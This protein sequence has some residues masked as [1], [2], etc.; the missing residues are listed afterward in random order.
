MRTARRAVT[1]VLEGLVLPVAAGAGIAA[2]A[3]TDPI[4][5]EQ[6]QLT[7]SMQKWAARG[8]PDYQI[9]LHWVCGECSASWSHVLRLTVRDGEV[10]AVFDVTAGV[11][12]EKDP[13]TLTVE[14]LFAYVQSGIDGLAYRLA[15]DYHPTLGYPVSVAIDWRERM[16][17]DEG[18]FVVSSLVPLP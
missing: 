12:V 15:A 4:A 7:A 6:V 1:A 3:P 2:C 14:E 10:T 11:A 16:V 9:E 18:G 17:D 13:R 5:S 8:Y